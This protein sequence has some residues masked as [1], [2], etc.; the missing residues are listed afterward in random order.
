MCVPVKPA[1]LET[2]RVT[3][4]RSGLGR[5]GG[6]SA[7]KLMLLK[8]GEAVALENEVVPVAEVTQLPTLTAS[9]RILQLRM[10]AEAGPAS[11]PRAAVAA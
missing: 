9:T 1:E 6:P 8:S 7:F 4:D 10:P 3:E 5:T 2:L 11:S